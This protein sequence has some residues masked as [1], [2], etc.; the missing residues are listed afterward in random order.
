MP[1]SAKVALVRILPSKEL[2]PGFEDRHLAAEPLERLREFH[3]DVAPAEHDQMLGDVVELKRF[4]VRQ[5]RRSG[6][7]G[8]VGQGR[9]RS[10]VEEDPLGFDPSGPFRYLHLDDSRTGEAPFAK[11]E[12][13]VVGAEA[14]AVD[15]DH[16]IH[17]VAL[18]LAHDLHVRGDRRDLQTIVAPVPSAVHDLCAVDDVFARKAGDVRA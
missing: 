2:G 16:P 5:R 9:A 12:L 11:D 10:E 15:L 14:L 4:D 7:A 8:D 6:K 17:Q 1:S 13:E 18:A 3:A